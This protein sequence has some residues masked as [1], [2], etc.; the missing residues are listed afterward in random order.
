[1][2]TGKRERWENKTL[3]RVRKHLHKNL[4]TLTF[5]STEDKDDIE[6]RAMAEVKETISS[7]SGHAV[8]LGS[9]SSSL[10]SDADFTAL[11]ILHRQGLQR[12]F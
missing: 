10:E 3:Q 8:E 6:N 9:A 12:E 11:S 2:T 1:M 5:T 4:A 7:L